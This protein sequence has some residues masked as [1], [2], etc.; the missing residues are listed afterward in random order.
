MDPFEFFQKLENAVRANIYPPTAEEEAK[1]SDHRRIRASGSMEGNSQIGT[2]LFVGIASLDFGMDRD[3]IKAYLS[4][5]EKE[6]SH[7]QG[8]F[9]S[10]L[11]KKNRKYVAK[12]KLIKKHLYLNGI[13]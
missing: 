10:K 12:V 1:L 13:K 3:D 7:K 4:I 9:M 5:D 11:S 8:K 6:Y 2:I